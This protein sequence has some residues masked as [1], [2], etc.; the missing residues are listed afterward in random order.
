MIIPTV[1]E[2]TPVGERA[3]DIYSRLLRDRV[4]FLGGPIDD[5]VANSVVAQLLFLDAD[6]AKQEIK[7]YI[8]SPGGSV[9]SALS[10]LDTMNLVRPNIVTVCVGMAASAAAVLLS[11]GTKGERASLPNSEIMIHQPY[12]GME[13]Q[14]SDLKIAT[15]RLLKRRDMLN[16]IL[17]TN[18]GKTPQEISE[19]VDRDNFMTPIEA[20]RYGL[21]DQVLS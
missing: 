15:D 5:I 16:K 4:I 2:K 13:G 9:S 1:L 7:L 11:A 14:V 6:N 8:N 17:A 10:I 20:K 18:T 12:G 3:F 21:I 19:A